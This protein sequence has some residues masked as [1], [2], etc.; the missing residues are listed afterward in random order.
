M[1][2]RTGTRTSGIETSARHR[3]RAAARREAEEAS[4]RGQNG[5]VILRFGDT[6]Y[7]LKA[8]VVREDLK[9]IRAAIIGGGAD[10]AQLI[11]EGVV[12]PES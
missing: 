11:A 9:R 12:R 6:V 7:Y 5:P 8:D 10:L 2:K 1:A 4:W 3:R